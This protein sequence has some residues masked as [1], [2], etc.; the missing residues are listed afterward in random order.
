MFVTVST[1][2]AKNFVTACPKKPP[3]YGLSPLDRVF[4]WPVLVFKTRT[5]LCVW[6]CW[7]RTKIILTTIFLLPWL[8][9]YH[10]YWWQVTIILAFSCNK[11]FYLFG[12]IREPE[13]WSWWH[14]GKGVMY[15]SQETKSTGMLIDMFIVHV[16]LNLQ[17]TFQDQ[18]NP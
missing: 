15:I 16:T 9:T 7:P 14:W 17:A 2:T 4:L 18:S 8:S 1:F 5:F 6:L 11:E 12:E 13:H 10:R 3:N